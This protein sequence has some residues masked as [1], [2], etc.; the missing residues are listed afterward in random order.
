MEPIIF[1]EATSRRIDDERVKLTEFGQLT[2]RVAANNL[3]IDVFLLNG[4]AQI[5]HARPHSHGIPPPQRF[6]KRNS[7]D[8]H[9]AEQVGRNAIFIELEAVKGSKLHQFVGLRRVHLEERG[10]RSRR[11]QCPDGFAP[12]TA[13]IEESERLELARLPVS[14]VITRTIDEAFTAVDRVFATAL[15]GKRTGRR[16]Q[17]H[18]QIARTVNDARLRD[19]CL[20]LRDP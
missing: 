1:R 9:A 13:A 17:S 2:R 14:A 6:A 15:R 11:V 12:K 5:A 4:V 7:E 19:G 10:A 3:D 16:P 18:F 20:N 8:A